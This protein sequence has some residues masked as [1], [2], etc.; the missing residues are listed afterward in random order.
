MTEKTSA[1]IAVTD[2][3]F[4][5]D[6]LMGFSAY[7]WATERI[8]GLDHNAIAAAICRAH[9]HD[10]PSLIP[11]SRGAGL[12]WRAPREPRSAGA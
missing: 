3:S 5:D 2:D 9:T 7:G 11:P 1:T 10:R 8:D 4:S 12:R 6:V